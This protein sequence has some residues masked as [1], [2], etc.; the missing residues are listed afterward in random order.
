MYRG[1]RLLDLAVAIPA[2]IATLPLQLVAATCVR[3]TLGAPIIFRQTRPGLHGEPF[4]MKKFR[5]MHPIDESKG[6]TD[7]ASRLTRLGRFLR[8]TSIDEL[9]ALW[10][11]A[12]GDMSLVGPRPLL[13]HY[14]KLYTPE[15][16]RRMDV[17]PGITGLAQVSG[18]NSLTWTDRFEIDLEYVDNCSFLLDL[19]ILAKTVVTVFGRR[20]ISED[21]EATMTE[22]TG[23]RYE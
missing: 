12:K 16:A 21:G 17:P 3:A 1:K 15:Q 14:L 7:D 6:W 18:R 11:V 20:G 2:L 22:F 23:G 5:T 10:N 13:M 4:V 9:P 8:S 19:Q